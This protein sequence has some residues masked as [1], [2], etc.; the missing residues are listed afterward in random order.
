MTN[1]PQSG[2]LIAFAGVYERPINGCYLRNYDFGCDRPKVRYCYDSVE[3]VRKR[4][5]REISFRD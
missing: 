3:K 2:D 1:D 4:Y 5:F